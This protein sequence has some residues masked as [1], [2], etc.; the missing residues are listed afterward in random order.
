MG[1]RSPGPCR[2]E[3]FSARM[4]P[5]GICSVTRFLHA[6][7]T[8]KSLSSPSK[9]CGLRPVRRDSYGKTSAS[10][11]ARRRSEEWRRQQPLRDGH[12]IAWCL[13]TIGVLRQDGARR[14]LLS[15]PFAAGRNDFLIIVITC[16]RLRA[17]PSHHACAMA[18]AGSC[19]VSAQHTVQ[20]QWR[21]PVPAE[22]KS[23]ARL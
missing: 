12:T 11:V 9:G 7:T 22:F 3:A 19:A 10:C 8:C 1:I 21:W 13:P 20:P 4:V 14:H 15:D 17:P 5:A 23:N 2:R 6:G 18:P 16:H